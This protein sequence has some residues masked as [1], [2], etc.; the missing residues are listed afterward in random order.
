MSAAARKRIEDGTHP[1][2][3][4]KKRKGKQ[5]RMTNHHKPRIYLSG[6]IRL[7]SNKERLSWRDSIIQR[8]RDK[9]DFLDPTVRN[10]NGDLDYSA[11]ISDKAKEIVEA[12]LSD[13][14]Q[15]DILLAN[16][17][18]YSAGTLMEVFFAKNQNKTVVCVVPESCLNDIWIKYHSNLIT[19]NFQAAF[20]YI[21]GQYFH[22]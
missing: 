5:H 9:Y 6:P 8:Y 22:Q 16:I 14:R 18:K 15:A 1:F 4:L 2:L 17:H 13:I 11:T 7:C 10:F 19:T 21:Q 3:H 20:D 12:D